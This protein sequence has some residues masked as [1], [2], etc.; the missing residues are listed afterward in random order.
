MLP[1]FPG[2]VLAGR[3]RLDVKL[4]E[5]GMGQV[6]AATHV[7]TRQPVA[8]KLL[9]PVLG[10]DGPR[11]V[12]R[13]MREARAAS[14]VRHPNVVVINDVMELDAE[15]PMMVMELLHGE[16]LG[17]RLSREKRL[18]VA[19]IARVLLPVVS[20]LGTAHALGIVHRDI[21]PDNI[22]LANTPEGV[23]VKVLDFGIAKLSPA[24]DDATTNTGTL[25]AT[26]AIVGTPQYMAPEQIF[27]EK[28]IDHRADIWALGVI[29]YECIA[30]AR[31]T[32]GSNVGQVMKIIAQQRIPPIA[33][34]APDVPADVAAMITSALATERD[35]RP[36][37]RDV[38]SVLSRYTD[39]S[40]RS[41]AEPQAPITLASGTSLP[42]SGDASGQHGAPATDPSL[43]TA[44]TIA[45]GE[46]SSERVPTLPT[47]ATLEAATTQLDAKSLPPP[48]KSSRWLTVVLAVIAVGA[49]SALTVSLV[50]RP[51]SSLSLAAPPST[52]PSVT[53]TPPTASVAEKHE[54]TS[55]KD[56]AVSSVVATPPSMTTVRPAPSTKP[57][58]NASATAPPIA[59]TK[60]TAAA[61]H[62]GVV[63]TVPY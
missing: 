50:S 44:P 24:H 48:R 21:K 26:N 34:V 1:L 63:E 40:V 45:S 15:T 29:A 22:F 20:A 8:L 43:G 14:A 36:T 6:W 28:D 59:P 7:V 38:M 51:S 39:M 56:A 60:Q 4:G 3:Y 58:A 35:Q 53:P 47:A 46:T 13:F 16:T 52:T 33:Q 49:T 54:D 31:P 18:P 27:G 9:L 19:E 5:G 11:V 61:A 30:G 2:T 10:T 12:K 32:E 23:Q 41:F 62:G 42:P 25:T 37:L 55:V 57:V 17:E